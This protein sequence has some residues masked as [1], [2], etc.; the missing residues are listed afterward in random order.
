MIRFARCSM[1]ALPWLVVP[2]PAAAQGTDRAFAE[3]L[4]RTGQE[5]MGAGN[6]AEACPKFA[7]SQ[8]L[9]PGTGTVLNLAL[10]H[11]REGKLASA[12]SEYNDVLTLARRDQRP[13]RVE[14]AQ[15]RLAAL[16]PRLSRL[17]IELAADG[18][19]PGLEV[20]LDGRVLGRPA[21]G[22]ATP[23]DPGVHRVSASA[24]GKQP[25]TSTIA[26]AAVA[27]DQKPMSST[28]QIPKLLAAPA[29]AV[30]AHAATPRGRPLE[31]VVG[32]ANGENDKALQVRRMGAYALG[33]LGLVGVGVGSF[34]GLRAISRYNLS[35]DEGCVGSQ[36]PP[37]AAETRRSARA[38]GDISTVAFVVGGVA[39]GTGIVL[40]LTSSRSPKESP[41]R[42]P[43]A[44]LSI[45]P[46]LASLGCVS[47]W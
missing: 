15:Q 6:Y 13:D 25:W 43:T 3:Q 19:V 7:E 35:N 20:R 23:V 17:T 2:G 30:P 11:E 37:G 26:I 18:D 27:S 31:P 16:E 4:F 47:T 33:G 8:R 39:L 29:A 40:Y 1:F 9:D 36:C 14:Y 41:I 28:V 32:T 45:A 44:T 21:L 24:P 5:L 38:A 12:W 22:I 42:V 10:C 46:G 34:F